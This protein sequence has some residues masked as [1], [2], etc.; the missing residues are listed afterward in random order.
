MPFGLGYKRK[1]NKSKFPLLALESSSAGF[2]GYDQND[3]SNTHSVNPRRT[4][5]PIL[6]STSKEA[7][8]SVVAYFPKL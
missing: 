2:Q 8:Y 5:F 1:Q 4:L 3:P 7:R 6:S